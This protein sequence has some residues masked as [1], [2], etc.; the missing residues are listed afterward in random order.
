MSKKHIGLILCITTISML[1]YTLFDLKGQVKEIPILKHQIDSLEYIKDS[2]YA[3][4]VPTEIELNRHKIAY[5]IFM[6]RNPKAASQY[7]TIISEETE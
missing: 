6:K 2:I 3:D 7:G 1:L 4:L 5:E